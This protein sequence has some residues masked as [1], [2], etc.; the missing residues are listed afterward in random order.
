MIVPADSKVV[1]VRV[2]TVVLRLIYGGKYLRTVVNRSFEIEEMPKL[3]SSIT[4]V[5]DSK[6]FEGVVIKIHEPNSFKSGTIIV[7][8]DL[9]KK[10]EFPTVKPWEPDRRKGDLM[11]GST[12]D[13]WFD[14]RRP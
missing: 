1:A 13:G 6:T 2:I 3:G 10:P 8:L 12:A 4:L 11:R 5:A 7:R 9:G 14:R